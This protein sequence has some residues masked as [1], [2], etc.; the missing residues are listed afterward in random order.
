M[1]FIQ[2][3]TEAG[4]TLGNKAY[5]REGQIVIICGGSGS[6]KSHVTDNLLLL[7]GKVL[8]T[9]NIKSLVLKISK[10]LS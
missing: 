8:D 6:G 4:I 7:D 3:L 5:P 2:L 10:E 1:K 9:D